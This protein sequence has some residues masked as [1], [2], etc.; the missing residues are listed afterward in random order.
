MPE[1]VSIDI[2]RGVILIDS[3][4]HIGE[5]DLRRS[6][7]SV[8]QL[9][10]RH[11][12]NKVMIDATG[13]RSL[14]SVFALYRFASELSAH[15]RNL[16]HAIVVSEQSPEDIRFVETAAHNR[17]TI[18]KLFSEREDAWSWLNQ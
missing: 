10:H 7:E 4:H 5:D 1:T 13:Q 17:G 15:A 6:L 18:M 16:R 8:L 2:E 12:I 11:G 9:A 14:P 3:S